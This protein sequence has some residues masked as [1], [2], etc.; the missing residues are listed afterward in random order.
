LAYFTT[1]VQSSGNVFTAGTLRLNVVDSD[2]SGSLTN[3]S[4]SIT[5]DNMKPGDTV[6]APIQIRNVGTLDAVYGIQYVTTTT[7]SQDLADALTLGVLGRGAAGTGTNTTTTTN[8]TSCNETSFAAGA[9]WTETIQA[10]GT[11]MT[12]GAT[13]VVLETAASATALLPATGIPVL[14]GASDTLCLQV[15]MP[16]GTDDSFNNAT[17]G[18]TNSTVVFT[19]DGL[20]SAAPQINNP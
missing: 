9:V 17:N 18:G 20:V 5:F 2:G 4:S 11:A 16:A 7:G 8:P 14:A 13:P 15:I 6:Y 10:S 19:F 3:A 12:A 1:Q